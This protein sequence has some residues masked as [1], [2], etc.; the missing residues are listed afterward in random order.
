MSKMMRSAALW[1]AH[2]SRSELLLTPVR[3]SPYAPRRRPVPSASAST[4]SEASTWPRG[5]NPSPYEVL[6]ISRG[7]PYSKSRF[8]QLVKRYHPDSSHPSSALPP[9]VRLERYRL[10]VAAN[11]L[12][13]DPAKRRLYDAHGIGWSPSSPSHSSSSPHR[14]EHDPS[15]RDRPGSAANNATWEDWAAWHE[16]RRRH[17]QQQSSDPRV[18]TLFGSD[19]EFCLILISLVFML[20]AWDFFGMGNSSRNQADRA[21]RQTAAIKEDVRRSSEATAVR[22]MDE[23]VNHFLKDRHRG[24]P[25]VSV[26]P[27]LGGPAASPLDDDGPPNRH[28]DD[29]PVRPLA[30]VE[31]VFVEDFDKGYHVEDVD[32]KPFIEPVPHGLISA[33]GPVTQGMATDAKVLGASVRAKRPAQLID[34]QDQDRDGVEDEKDDLVDVGPREE[35][36]VEA[37]DDAHGGAVAPRAGIAATGTELLLL[38][39][40]LKGVVEVDGLAG[41]DDGQEVLCEEA[42]KGVP[43]VDALA[44]EADLDEKHGQD[45][46]LADV[47]GDGG[48]DDDLG[49]EG[50]ALGA[51]DDGEDGG[52]LDGEDEPALGFLELDEG[53]REGDAG[54]RQG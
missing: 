24:G 2:G 50:A 37:V 36:Q 9:S 19:I 11:D 34:Q 48:V 26:D 29:L 39:K 32:D 54:P 7:A 23:S 25:E 20:S 45:A 31:A 40:Q 41:G 16:A 43:V 21:Q 18:N 10:V 28:G 13:S 51:D 15:W 1:L 46:V 4:S 5:P 52:D 42:D 14:R 27:F 33:D 30:G 17:Q 38:A 8:Y 49:P 6:G 35:I 22:T 3:P 47:K 53:R 12:L 44:V